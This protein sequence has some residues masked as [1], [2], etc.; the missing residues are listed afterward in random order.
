MAINVML[1]GHGLAQIYG[2]SKYDEEFDVNEACVRASGVN[3]ETAN[4]LQRNRNRSAIASFV[5]FSVCN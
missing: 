2:K 5:F 1:I 4:I 3:I